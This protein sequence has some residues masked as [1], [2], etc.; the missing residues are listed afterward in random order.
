M[1]APVAP[2]AVL[3]AK[4][5]MMPPLAQ[6]AKPPPMELRQTAHARPAPG[7]MGL[8]PRN[9]GPALQHNLS[10]PLLKYARTAAVAAK[11]V[12]SLTHAQPVSTPNKELRQTAHARTAPGPM[13]LLPRNA[14]PVLHHNLSTP[15]LKPARTVQL[16]ARRAHLLRRVVHALLV[17]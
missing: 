17:T 11:P 7:P 4:R 1:V 9:A 6:N 8:L 5:A 14:G 10:I 12:L 13:G 16:A 3:G 15:P 2:D